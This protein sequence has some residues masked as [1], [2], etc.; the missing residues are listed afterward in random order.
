VKCRHKGITEVDKHGKREL[1]MVGWPIIQLFHNV[2]ASE[3]LG[4]YEYSIT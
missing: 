1:N 4:K 2:K 3:G